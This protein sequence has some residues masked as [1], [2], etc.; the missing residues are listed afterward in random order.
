ME[1][2]RGV[3]L[4]DL[5]RAAAR[6]NKPMPLAV[7]IGIV[8]QVCMALHHAHERR[9]REGRALRIVHRDVTR[10][11]SCCRSTQW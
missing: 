9:D 1:Y 2:V 3:S 4:A 8:H 11:T 5:C 10:T 6:A 7:A